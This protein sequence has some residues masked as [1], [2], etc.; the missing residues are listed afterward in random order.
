MRID[1]RV[2][3]RRTCA[4]RIAAAF[5]LLLAMAALQPAVASAQP[6]IA[7]SLLELHGITQQNIMATAEDLSQEI[8]DFRPT[9]EVR[10]TGQILAHVANA[11]FMFCS[12]AAGEDSPNAENFEQTRT[13][14][15]QIVEALRMGFEYCAGGRNERHG[16][17]RGAHDSV[18]ARHRNDCGERPRLQLGA[19]LRALRKPG[20]LHAA[21]RC[22][23]AVV[24]LTAISS[25][26]R[27]FST[28]ACL[29]GLSRP[30]RL[31]SRPGC[32]PTAP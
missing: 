16:S 25:R 30:A 14:K 6:T 4:R 24:A 17:G 9:E 15:A 11:Q 13:T 28:A 5:A 27:S 26:W 8:Y 29:S 1:R 23:A 32:P 18:H 10:T 2:T 31:R 12:M 22:R 7:G 20:H 21:E 19:Q 3:N